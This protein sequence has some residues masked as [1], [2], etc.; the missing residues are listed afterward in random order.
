MHVLCSSHC[1]AACDVQQLNARG[2]Q[3]AACV[4]LPWPARVK[5]C[6]T[7]RCQ[8]NRHPSSKDL[9]GPNLTDQCEAKLKAY[10]LGVTIANVHLL[11]VHQHRS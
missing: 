4:T 5:R 8:A 2:Q 7:T 10:L 11:P 9:L 3:T 1:L 6:Q